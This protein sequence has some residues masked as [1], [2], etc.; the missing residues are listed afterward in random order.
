[1]RT[2]TQILISFFIAV[3]AAPA[4]VAESVEV[5]WIEAFDGPP[6]SF[7]ILRGKEKIEGAIFEPIHDGDWIVIREDGYALSLGLGGNRTI[8]LTQM[9]TPFL[10]SATGEPP[11]LAGSLMAWAQDLFR[12]SHEQHGIDPAQS[13]VIRTFEA[14]DNL[15]IP[16]LNKME[17]QLVVADQSIFLAWHGGRAP[18]EVRV[19]GDAGAE[20]LLDIR[21]IPNERV[22]LEL[23]HWPPG[24]YRVEI[25]GSSQPSSADGKAVTTA[26][27]R[28]EVV[29]ADAF[30]GLPE[31]FAAEL[32]NSSMPDNAKTVLKGAWLAEAEDGRWALEAYQRVASLPEDYYPAYLLQQSLA[33]G[34]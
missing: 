33:A 31:D 21:D 34:E 6:D 2:I 27:G 29:S 16:L 20:P 24:D 10:I 5:G 13:M 7:V 17:K 14:A 25:R 22:E 12:K 18:F 15:S 23:D 32:A 11:G 28:F 9:Q 26:S 8:E 1:M 19:F 30:P 3:F 4:G